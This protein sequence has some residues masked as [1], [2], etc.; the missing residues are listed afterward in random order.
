MDLAKCK[1]D[2]LGIFHAIIYITKSE[3]FSDALFNPQYNFDAFDFLRA[4]NATGERFN[5]MEFLS[6]LIPYMPNN[7]FDPSSGIPLLAF[8]CIYSI[9][10][11]FNCEWV[12]VNMIKTMNGI[13]LQSQCSTTLPILASFIYHDKPDQRN[14]IITRLFEAGCG[15]NQIVYLRNDARL[16]YRE[17]LSKVMFGENNIYLGEMDLA[18][19]HIL[20]RKI[21]E[22]FRDSGIQE[23]SLLFIGAITGD[24]DLA[25]LLLSH[26]GNPN[27]VY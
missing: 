23:I 17:R 11:G 4:L 6:V 10:E 21:E 7:L 27:L 5:R 22:I 24:I 25:T 19:Y 9:A 16:F 14:Q 20:M 1:D 3:G 18:N 15:P 26:G 2:F 8:I 13:C 12:S